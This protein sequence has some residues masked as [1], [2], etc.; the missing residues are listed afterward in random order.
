M[1]RHIKLNPGNVVII[2]LIAV[3]S[4]I[5]T[6]KVLEFMQQRNLPNSAAVRLVSPP[7]LAAAA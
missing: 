7:P 3:T 1:D 2:G 6:Y 5:V 4:I